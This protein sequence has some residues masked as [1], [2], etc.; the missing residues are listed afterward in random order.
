M[1]LDVRSF[2]VALV[3]D[4]L[5]NEGAAGF[6]LLDLLDR[7]GWGVITLPPGW[8]PESVAGPLLAEVADHVA[9]F[10]RNGYAIVLIGRRAG[11]EAALAAVG[12]AAPQPIDSRDPAQLQVAL[13]AAAADLAPRDAAAAQ[14]ASS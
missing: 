7:A 6:D 8:Y 3:A 4:E 10:W 11:L 14:R 2:C 1:E 12:I 13:A 5:I 9:E